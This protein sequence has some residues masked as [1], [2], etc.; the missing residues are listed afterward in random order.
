MRARHASHPVQTLAVAFLGWKA[1]LLAIAAGTRVGSTYDTSTTL[2]LAGLN[3]S[4]PALLTRLTSW[5]AIYFVQIARRGYLFEQE[6][7]FGY[8]L[9]AII[10]LS[11]G[12][13]SPSAH[14]SA[15][16]SGAT[17]TCSVQR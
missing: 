16:A 4:Q 11:K 2:M 8:G 13:G 12:S 7:A 6:W 5:D 15:A 3:Q 1:L 17:P 14:G 9:P 10:S